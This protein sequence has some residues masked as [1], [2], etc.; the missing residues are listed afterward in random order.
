MLQVLLQ[1]GR[2]RWSIENSWH[3]LH[4]TQ[5][6]EDAHRYREVNGVQVMATLRRLAR[7]PSS[8]GNWVTSYEP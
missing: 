6:K 7:T 4:D 8:T 1:H 3:W 5:L 2:D